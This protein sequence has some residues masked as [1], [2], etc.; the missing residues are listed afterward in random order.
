ME[1]ETS[2]LLP[3][4]SIG[5][6]AEDQGL[7]DAVRSLENDWR[8]ERIRIDVQK[9]NVETAIS[10][11]SAIDNY[12]V[13][14]IET[15][16]VDDSFVKRLEAL[17]EYVSEDTAAIIVGPVNDVNLYRKLIAMGVSDYLVLPVPQ[18]VIGDIIAKS[19]IKIF[20]VSG[21]KL[22]ACLGAKGGVGTSAIS[23]VLGLLIGQKLGE[24]T[25]VLDAAGGRSF[26]AA[27]MGQ[28]PTTTLEAAAKAAVSPDKDNLKR[29]LLSIKDKTFVLAT[30]GEASLDKTIQASQFEDILDNL[31]AEYPVT[32]VD[33]SQANAEISKMVVAK[34]HKTFLISHPT[35][36]SLR[37]AR[38][39]QQEIQEIKGGDKDVSSPAL[40]INM[41]GLFDKQEVPVSEIE[42]GVGKKAD[43]VIPFETKCFPA[44]ELDGTL[45]N[46]NKFCAEV[47]R[48]L[49]TLIDDILKTSPDNEEEKEEKGG[50]LDN[51]MKPFKK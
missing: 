36:Q 40:I 10:A 38:T 17:S 28:E 25:V 1:I 2:T 37:A 19:L 7:R 41:K 44:S 50:L 18:E 27:S 32:I 20:G 3:A 43:M 46:E 13:L 6:F 21:S 39:L 47:A 26:L 33:L 8:F 15:D 45:L 23:H 5:V 34:A 35:V 11:K 9:G 31:M 48:K 22:I 51:I 24:K 16:T 14:V 49:M 29:M 42:K 12:N 30:G 4:G